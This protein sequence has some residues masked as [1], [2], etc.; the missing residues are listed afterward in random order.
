MSTPVQSAIGKIEGIFRRGIPDIKRATL[1]ALAVVLFAF[2]AWADD[3]AYNRYFYQAQV[4]FNDAATGECVARCNEV[5]NQCAQA[6]PDQKSGRCLG[7][8]T[9]CVA[10]CNAPPRR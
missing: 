2:S 3:G 10:A 5:Y 4:R 8:R 6:L 7:Q 9:E 1:F